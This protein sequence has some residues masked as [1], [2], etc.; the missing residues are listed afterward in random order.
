MRLKSLLV[1]ISFFVVLTFVPVS[2]VKSAEPTL[3]L[4]VPVLVLDYYPRDPSRP[5]YL[6][7]QETGWGGNN[8]G[9]LTIKDWEDRTSQMINSAIPIINEATK[10][11]GYKNPN[12]PQFLNYFILEN[13]KFYTAMPRGVKVPWNNANRPNYRQ[14]LREQNICDYVDNKGVK[15]VWIYSYHS[16]VIEPDE[17]RMSSKYGDISNAQ[18]KEENIT[19]EFRMP[20]CG[21]S[22]VL[23]NFTYQPT[24]VI[25]NTI[26][27]RLHQ[28]ENI[29][30]FAEGPS[31]WPPDQR[32]NS[33][34]KGSIF[35]GNFA[36]YGN[37]RDDINGE[38]VRSCGNS[39]FTPNGNT[40]TDYGYDL[41]NTESNNCETWQP[42]RSQTQFTSINCQRWGCTDYGYYK[43]WLQN[44]P[45]YNNGIVYQG[46]KMRNW[47]EGMYDFNAFVE[48]GRSL[49]AESIFQTTSLPPSS[50]STPVVTNT[51]TPTTVISSTVTVTPLTISSVT[52]SGNA[53]NLNGSQ[54][55]ITLTNSE[56]N[57]Y[58]AL[59]DV[60]DSKGAV[61]NF[62][63]KFVYQPP[64]T[65]VPTVTNTPTQV[66]TSAPNRENSQ[67]EVLQIVYPV[68]GQTMDLENSYMLKVK[69]IS[70]SEGYLFGLFQ[71]GNMVYEN[72]RDG[73]SLS[74]DGEFALHPEN[75]FHAKFHE[76]E[77][78]V[79][80][81][82]LSRGQWSPPLEIKF[83]LKPQKS[84]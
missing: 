55:L 24:A 79:Q 73:G 17:S 61:R 10:Y 77:V 20:I 69:T 37:P 32:T 78:K 84:R 82:V 7:P 5:D 45:G 36:L 72:L 33:N 15:E 75:P 57:V 63:V 76:G 81:R 11:H 80:V 66:P 34:V 47:W 42:D 26:H 71:D 58:N 64:V 31:F 22:Y 12:T 39:H 52:F 4:E 53:L 41:Q 40:T 62:V 8:W 6:D 35:W 27:N 13:K 44:I 9:N 67:I 18:P 74:F 1:I 70:K 25:G 83:Y 43:W 2:E 23:Y 49:Y 54:S 48:K 14:I 60:M 46:K 59:I 29:I 21:N 65:I 3:P 30:P 28:V 38:V 56:N 50:V 51:P 16:S 68:N 19:P